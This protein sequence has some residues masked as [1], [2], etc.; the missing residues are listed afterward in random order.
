VPVVTDWVPAVIS[1]A[2]GLAGVA[3]G[4][5]VTFVVQRADQDERRRGELAVALSAYGRAIDVL[6]REL[7]RLP[8]STRFARITER[9]INRQRTPGLEYLLGSMHSAT[10]GR[11]GIRAVEAFETAANRLMLIAPEDVLEAMEMTSQLLGQPRDETWPARWQSARE[12][13]AVA[14]RR[15][16]QAR[17]RRRPTAR[18]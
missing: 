18:E 4:G 8:A 2:S 12:Q 15:H 10:L 11:S 9:L 16:I 14:S 7:E 13:L 17:R 5:G 3:I 1:A 6:R